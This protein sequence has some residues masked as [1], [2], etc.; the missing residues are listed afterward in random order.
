M[1]YSYRNSTYNNYYN[2]RCSHFYT[3]NNVGNH[4]DAAQADSNVIGYKQRAQRLRNSCT[5]IKV[6]QNIALIIA[7]F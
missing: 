4:I 5:L 6:L 3:D 2:M 7:A 1:S